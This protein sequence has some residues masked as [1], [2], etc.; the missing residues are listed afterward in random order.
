MHGILWTAMTLQSSSGSGAEERRH[1]ADLLG[2]LDIALPDFEVKKGFLAQAK[3]AEPGIPMSNSEWDRMTE[4]CETMLSRTPDA[5][6]FGYSDER[7][8]RVYP[9]TA[10]VGSDTRDLFDLYDRSIRSF[11]ES[12][13]ECF[14]GDHRLNSP[15]IETLD[16]LADLP[17]RRVLKLSARA[18]R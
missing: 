10:V 7:G 2:V 9:A 16:A 18:A 13:L 17:V 14:I 3:R 6:V 12:H 1:G 8:I 11:F 5:F 15:D 4:Q